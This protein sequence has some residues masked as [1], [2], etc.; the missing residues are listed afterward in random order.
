MKNYFESSDE[1]VGAILSWFMNVVSLSAVLCFTFGLS[2]SV[3]SGLYGLA[4]L[5]FFATLVVKSAC[6]F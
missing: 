5:I 1:E 4:R 3:V 2:E 6:R